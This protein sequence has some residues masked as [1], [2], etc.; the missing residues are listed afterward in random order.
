MSKLM[1]FLKIY[2]RTT[3]WFLLGLLVL[4]IT[5]YSAMR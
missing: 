5:I 3:L 1:E 2:I 4:G